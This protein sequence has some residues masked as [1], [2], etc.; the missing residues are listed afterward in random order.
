MADG[1]WLGWGSNLISGAAKAV[2]GAMGYDELEATDP[3][4]QG[5]DGKASRLDERTDD[6]KAMFT[7]LRQYIG[8]D[9]ISLMSIPVWLMEPLTVLQKAAENME[10][11]EL[12]ERAAH[13]EDPA[14]RLALVAAF[15]SS[16]YASSERTYKPFNP[17]LGETFEMEGIVDGMWYIAEQVSHH[18]PV[19]AAH[20]E[21]KSWSYDL[22]SSPKTKFMGNWIDV[23]P[24]G[25]TRITLKTTGETFGLITPVTRVQNLIVGRMWVDNVGPMKVTNLTTGWVCKLEYKPCGWF[26][27]GRYEVDGAVWDKDEGGEAKLAVFGKWVE[28]LACAECDAEGAPLEKAGDIPL[29]EAKQPIED[30]PYNFMEFT[31]HLNSTASAPKEKALLASDSRYRPDR[32]ALEKEDNGEA[33]SQKHTLEERQRAEQR[34]REEKGD[35][36][37]PRFFKVAEPADDSNPETPTDIWVITDAYAERRASGPASDAAAD[38]P[39]FSPWQYGPEIAA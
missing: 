33:Q 30:D 35:T 34:E 27:A 31:H 22:T 39:E 12:L 21:G 7:Q 5:A 17:I 32:A 8:A 38:A 4:A 6:R 15:C 36:W 14:K 11:C 10:Y 2:T 26:G 16:V 28:G 1:G 20:G 3:N 25:R 18:P 24:V 37:T 9:V 19:C 13:E 29:W 23:F